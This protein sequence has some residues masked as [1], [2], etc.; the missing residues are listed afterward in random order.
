MKSWLRPRAG[1]A[2][3]LLLPLMLGCVGEPPADDRVVE[4]ASGAHEWTTADGNRLPYDVGGNA[5]AEVT[6]VLVHC[7]MCDRSFWKE[8][9]PALASDYRTV[10]LDLPGHGAASAERDPW[11][12][13]TYGEDVAGLIDALAL[14]DVVLVG[15]SMGG[16]VSLRAAARLPGKVRGIVAVDTLHDADFEWEGEQ[17]QGMIAAF[18]ADFVGTCET[19]VDRRFPEQGVDE[20]KD[21]VRKTGCD[22]RRSATGSALMRDFPRIDMPAWFREAGVPIRAINAAAPTPTNVEGNREYADFEVRLMEGVGHYLH[23]TRPERFNPLLL[24]AIAELTGA[25]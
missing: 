6:V 12:V 21:H 11:R 14:D 20:V 9:L 15:H 24:Q 4:L 5:D 10:A 22:G 18:E 19:F 8:Q 7:W 13:A 16:P 3:A 1:S 2:F 25:D 17:V 23:M